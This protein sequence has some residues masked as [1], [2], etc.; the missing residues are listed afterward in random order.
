MF[1]MRSSPAAIPVGGTRARHPVAR[2][3]DDHGESCHQPVRGGPHALGKCPGAL[4]LQHDHEVIGNLY[5]ITSFAL[6]LIA[7]LMA[8]LIRAERYSPELQIGAPDVA[9][10]RF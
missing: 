9:F 1:G 2:P 10:L 4:G 3:D 5:L 7:V 8:L 6:F